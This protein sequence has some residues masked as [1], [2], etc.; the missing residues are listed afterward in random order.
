MRLSSIV[1]YY[2][3]IVL[4]MM[5]VPITVSAEIGHW[6]VWEDWNKIERVSAFIRESDKEPKFADNTEETME[7][8]FHL[9][10]QMRKEKNGVCPRLRNHIL[11]YL[12]Q[13]TEFYETRANTLVLLYIHLECQPILIDLAEEMIG[14]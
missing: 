8:L 13:R 4:I 1:L 12:K 2:I 3:S 5:S 7:N 6:M 11:Y 10:E 14:E 9:E